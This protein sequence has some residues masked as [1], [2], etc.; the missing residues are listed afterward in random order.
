[1]RLNIKPK[2]IIHYYTYLF[3]YLAKSKQH[4]NLYL[5]LFRFLKKV[6]NIYYLFSETKICQNDLFIYSEQYFNL[7]LS[8]LRF[9]K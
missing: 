2:W 6:V 8:F 1:M 3:I 9:E 4:F 7:Y 5:V